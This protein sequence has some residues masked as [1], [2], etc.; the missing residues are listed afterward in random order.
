MSTQ[1]MHLVASGSDVC[2]EVIMARVTCG[3]CHTEHMKLRHFEAIFNSI[4]SQE[5]YGQNH[6]II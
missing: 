5:T 3:V 1:K 6:E 4:Q 2:T